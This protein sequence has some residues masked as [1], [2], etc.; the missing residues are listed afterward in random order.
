VIGVDRR[1]PPEVSG[2]APGRS[3]VPTHPNSLWKL[4]LGLGASTEVLAFVGFVWSLRGPS[5]GSRPPSALD[6]VFGYAQF[7]GIFSGMG[8]AD[9]IG[10]SVPSAVQPLVLLFAIAIGF[11]IQMVLFAFPIWFITSWVRRLR[12]NRRGTG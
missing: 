7:P 6:L 2:E 5:D 11:A 8:I 4:A 10:G 9:T 12:P 1:D 3:S